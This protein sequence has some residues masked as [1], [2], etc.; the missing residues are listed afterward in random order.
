MRDDVIE[1]GNEGDSNEHLL[2]REALYVSSGELKF[3]RDGETEEDSHQMTGEKQTFIAYISPRWNERWNVEGAVRER[4]RECG[5]V[6]VTWQWR[7]AFI[8]R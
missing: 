4:W 6:D 2:G 1:L 8:M 5:E 7:L 3:G